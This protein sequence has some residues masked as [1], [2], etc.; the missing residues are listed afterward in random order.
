M[1]EHVQSDYNYAW[2]MVS[3]EQML[4]FIIICFIIISKINGLV[5]H[6]ALIIRRLCAKVKTG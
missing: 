3:T 2:H 1:N 6:R 5:W 4:A